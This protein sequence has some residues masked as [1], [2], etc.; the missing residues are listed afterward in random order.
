MVR[1]RLQPVSGAAGY[2]VE[3]ASDAEFTDRLGRVQSNGP[4]ASFSDIANGRYYVRASAVD[5]YG[6]SGRPVVLTFERRQPGAD[7]RASEGDATG[8]VGLSEVIAAAQS[9]LGLADWFPGY[10]AQA[11]GVSAASTAVEADAGDAAAGPSAAEESALATFSALS[12]LSSDDLE[13]S[14]IGAFGMA[15]APLSRGGQLSSS[16]SG[17]AG[18][19]GGSGGAGGGRPGSPSDRDDSAGGSDSGVT[20]IPTDPAPVSPFP[21]GGSSGDGDS[22]GNG[23]PDFNIPD[24]GWNSNIIVP[25]P[26]SWVLMITGFGVVGG[27]LR[28]RRRRACAG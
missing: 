5:G 18:G 25:E 21:P 1:F 23:G 26:A 19:S 3:I 10:G 11:G 9:M 12:A 24:S 8:I 14:G 15:Q 17:S 4:T 20:I 7:G 22:S 13:M 6:L 16:G 27:L 2:I 28:G